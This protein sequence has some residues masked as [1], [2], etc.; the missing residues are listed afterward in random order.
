VIEPDEA[1]LVALRV[2]KEGAER[3][4]KDDDFR[5]IAESAL[6]AAS[7]HEGRLN[8]RISLNDWRC[9]ARSMP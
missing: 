2:P 1:S 7:H 3:L 9:S 5:V 4:P 6:R 8:D